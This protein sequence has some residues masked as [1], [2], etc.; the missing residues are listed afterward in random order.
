MDTLT[1]IEPLLAAGIGISWLV[2]R[3][4]NRPLK[5]FE[6]ASREAAEG[7]LHTESVSVLKTLY[8]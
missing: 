2:Q 7:R 3:W 4:K 6:A 1:C 5:I 8:K